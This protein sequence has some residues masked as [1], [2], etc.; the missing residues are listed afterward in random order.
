MYLDDEKEQINDLSE[1][2]ARI[3]EAGLRLEQRRLSAGEVYRDEHPEFLRDY[4]ADEP[5]ETKKLKRELE[6]EALMRLEDAARTE[7]D[8][9][10]VV[11]I[12]DRLDRNRERKERY[13]E[14]PRW[15]VP[16]EYN[17]AEGGSVFPLWLSDPA[18]QQVQRGDFLEI[19]FDCPHLMHENLTDDVLYELAGKL[20]DDHKLVL[21][22]LALRQYSCVRLAAMRGQTDRNIRKVR[23]TIRRKLQ[24]QMYRELNRRKQKDIPITHF[25]RDFMRKYEARQ[26]AK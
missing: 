14:I 21:Y 22:F 1:R 4:Y 15:Q 13:H 6:R 19:L 10:E 18:V 2:E 26:E 11:K 9:R 17:R 5:E 8:F 12:W 16:L 3:V 7:A 25:Q 24:R 20:K 23:G